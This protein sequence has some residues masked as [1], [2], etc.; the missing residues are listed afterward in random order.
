VD[1]N[2][3]FN[4]QHDPAPTKRRHMQFREDAAIRLPLRQPLV[5]IMERSAL[6]V[7][8]VFEFIA[9]ENLAGCC[10]GSSAGLAPRGASQK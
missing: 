8:A 3:L 4:S 2:N 10:T 7:A 9:R 5:A 1:L 6:R